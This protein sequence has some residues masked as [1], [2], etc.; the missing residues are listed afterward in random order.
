MREQQSHTRGTRATA[1]ARRGVVALA[2]AALL[3][4]RRSS[5]AGGCQRRHD[6]AKARG[7]PERDTTAAAQAQGGASRP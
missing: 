4:A 5:P 2:L 1:V 3:V 6:A 7:E